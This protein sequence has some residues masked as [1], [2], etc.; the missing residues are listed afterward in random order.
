MSC[1]TGSPREPVRSVDEGRAIFATD[2]V[3]YNR[4]IWP[5][6][7]R[8]ALRD[9]SVAEEVIVGDNDVGIAAEPYSADACLKLF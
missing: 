6:G 9:E 5:F 1:L 8:I 3:V 4:Q 2:E 7:Q